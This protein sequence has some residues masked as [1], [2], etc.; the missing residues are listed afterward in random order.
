MGEEDGDVGAQR[1]VEE[2]GGDGATVDSL[3][4][5]GAGGGRPGAGAGSEGVGE[6]GEGEE[7]RAARH[8]C[9]GVG[10][11][12]AGFGGAVQKLKS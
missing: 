3:E 5:A 12:A 1:A 8:G 10:Q 11:G 2:I 6:Q 4:V 9:S 7:R